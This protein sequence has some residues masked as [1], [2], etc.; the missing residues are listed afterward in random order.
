MKRSIAHPVFE[1]CREPA[2]FAVWGRGVRLYAARPLHWG[3]AGG[4]ISRASNGNALETGGGQFG[5][6][7]MGH[8]AILFG[9]EVGKEKDAMLT[10]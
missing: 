3:W 8:G 5:Q 4:R 10:D 7:G 1:R 2:E 9:W 6:F